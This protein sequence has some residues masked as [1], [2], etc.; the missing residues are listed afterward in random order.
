MKKEFS[1]LPKSQRAAY[2]LKLII[3]LFSMVGSLLLFMALVM[4][5]A[6]Q[7]PSWILKTDLFT[8]LLLGGIGFS[9]LGG[10][11][12]A[13]VIK[14]AMNLYTDMD[15]ERIEKNLKRVKDALKE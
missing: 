10:V 3:D 5:E 8:Y 2:N 1:D 15:V 13:Y 4:F 9:L 12:L 6:V 11:F 7:Y 14:Q